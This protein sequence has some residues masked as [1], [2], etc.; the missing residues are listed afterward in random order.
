MTERN[1]LA[2]PP[3]SL[4]ATRLADLART[5]RMVF[6]AGLPGVGKSLLIRELAHI[7]HG[8][9]RRV[10]LLQWDVAR[11]PFVTDAVVNK[12]PRVNG[13]HHPVIRKAM[14]VW[15]RHAVAGWHEANPGDAALL[16]GE[17][18]LIG[19]RFIELATP[20]NDDAEPLLVAK[21][22]TF[23]VPVPSRTVRKAIESARAVTTANPKHDRESGDARPN[24]MHAIWEELLETA[25]VLGIGTPGDGSYNPESYES[26]Y[27]AVLK[28][29]H[30][31]VLPI[32]FTLPTNNRSVYDLDV[33]YQDV[34]P[35]E[36]E[37]EAFIAQVEQTYP[38]LA[39]LE[40]EVARWY[41]V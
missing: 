30:A 17:T 1:S 29:R 2:L 3:D 39:V 26:V 41:V 22:T 13:V 31:E 7:A 28:H 33:P 34:M 19:N 38:D 12:Y 37:G 8:L 20:S 14:G 24:V 9:G 27:S 21:N 25:S 15:S 36:G 40:K 5:Q 23:L 35:S 10:H 4:V 18:P 11:Q 6:F 16:I 32:D